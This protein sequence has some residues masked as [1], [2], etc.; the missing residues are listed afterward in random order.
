MF[1]VLWRLIKFVVR[2]SNT[3]PRA[4]IITEYRHPRCGATMS[5]SLF[6]PE[7]LSQQGRALFCILATPWN[8]GDDGIRKAMQD[9][10]GDGNFGIYLMRERRRWCK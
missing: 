7:I 4:A 5:C 6:K 10:K 9:A 3:M 8:R 2:N 1:V